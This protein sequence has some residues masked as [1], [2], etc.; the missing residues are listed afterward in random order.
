MNYSMEGHSECLYAGG[1]RKIPVPFG[2]SLV[3]LVGLFSLCLVS[4]TYGFKQPRNDTENYP[5]PR[6][7]KFGDDYEQVLKVAQDHETLSLVMGQAVYDLGLG[8]AATVIVPKDDLGLGDT[9]T[10]IVP[11]EKESVIDKRAIERLTGREPV[12][13]DYDSCLDDERIERLVRS[14]RVREYPKGVI[15][16]RGLDTQQDNRWVFV[17]TKGGDDKNIYLVPLSMVPEARP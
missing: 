10:E 5:P 7:Y 8:N 4:V 15:V 2:R 1:P 12:V 13:V 11:K 17:S 9:E 6:I 14:A 3:S 16:L